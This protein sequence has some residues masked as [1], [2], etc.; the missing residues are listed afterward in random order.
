MPFD[1]TFVSNNEAPTLITSNSAKEFANKIKH[2]HQS[3]QE[4]IKLSQVRMENQ[5]NTSRTPAPIYQPGDYV[6]LS[7]KNVKTT[8]PS[9]KLDFKSCRAKVLERKSTN[10]Y[11]LELPDGLKDLWPV[12]HVSLLRPDN[13]DPLPGQNNPPPPSITI[14]DDTGGHD[15][16]EAEEVLDSRL[17]YGRCQ[18]RVKWKG[19]G[20]DLQWYNADGFDNAPELVNTFYNKYPEKPR[21]P[22]PLTR[23]KATQRRLHKNQVQERRLTRL[24]ATR[25]S[26]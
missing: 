2:L 6:W 8:R 14:Q 4:E 15:E 7:L 5:A 9:K 23:D 1:N 11:K 22:Q 19:Y 16:W 18:Y 24:R 26:S 21:P 17:Y 12:F 20:P 3:L 25:E 10:A 13:N